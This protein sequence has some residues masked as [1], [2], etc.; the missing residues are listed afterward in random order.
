M[1]IHMPSL[2]DRQEDIGRLVEH[3]L[4]LHSGQYKPEQAKLSA[5][6]LKQLLDYAWPGNVRERLFR[7]GHE[8][9]SR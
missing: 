9:A 2:R 7:T 6:T 8:Q 3:F 1:P 5:N 4:T